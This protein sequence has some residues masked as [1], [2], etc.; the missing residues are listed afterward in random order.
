VHAK[1]FA[2]VQILARDAQT[3]CPYSPLPAPPAIRLAHFI[4][5]AEKNDRRFLPSIYALLSDIGKNREIN[6][7]HGRPPARPSKGWR[8][9]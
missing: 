7:L 8:N 4:P 3:H 9:G 5:T 2:D 1:S 6:P